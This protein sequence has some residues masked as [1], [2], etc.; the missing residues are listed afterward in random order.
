MVILRFENGRKRCIANTA[1][2]KFVSFLART[3]LPVGKTIARI[4]R[5]LNSYQ[6]IEFVRR[7]A[8][9]FHSTITAVVACYIHIHVNRL[10]RNT[11]YRIARLTYRIGARRAGCTRIP[12]FQLVTTIWCSSECY[13]LFV[14]A[15]GIGRSYFTLT[16][17]HFCTDIVRQWAEIGRKGRV[18]GA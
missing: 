12:R 9:H 6:R 16:A 1:N 2:S 15:V 3:T 4:R 14:F 13:R 10:E 7:S 5:R 8:N 11:H 17:D 18:L